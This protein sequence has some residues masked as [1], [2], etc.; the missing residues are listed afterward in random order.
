[1]LE[2]QKKVRQCLLQ[3]KVKK[4]VQTQYGTVGVRSHTTAAPTLSLLS[5]LPFLKL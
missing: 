4:K 2:G 1:M 3:S 5:D